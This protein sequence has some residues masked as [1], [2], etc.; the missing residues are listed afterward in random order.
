[1]FHNGMNQ[2]C[3]QISQLP[4]TDCVT[5]PKSLNLSELPFHQYNGRKPVKV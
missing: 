5:L 1:M 4:L 2:L 3:L